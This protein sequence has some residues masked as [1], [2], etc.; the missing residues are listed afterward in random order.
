M[1]RAAVVQ[2]LARMAYD[3]SEPR[4]ID[5]QA[6]RRRKRDRQA[7]KANRRRR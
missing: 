3:A 7:R 1:K 2:Q 4:P 5:R 6:L